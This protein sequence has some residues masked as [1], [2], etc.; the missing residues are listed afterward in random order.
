[1]RDYDKAAYINMHTWCAC[2]L[3]L[4]FVINLN[5]LLRKNVG[6]NKQEGCY[7]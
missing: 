7:V 6:D 5:G 3:L 2:A 1:M 4:G